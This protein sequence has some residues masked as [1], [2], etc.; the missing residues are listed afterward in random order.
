MVSLMYRDSLDPSFDAKIMTPPIDKLSEAFAKPVCVTDQKGS[1]RETVGDYL[2][3]YGAGSFFQTTTPHAANS[4]PFSQFKLFGG[5]SR[6]TR[7]VDAYCGA[8]PFAIS[9]SAVFE[10][11][12]KIELS[13]TSITS[14]KRN[15]QLNSISSDKISFLPGE[16][17]NIFA[18]VKD[19]PPEQTVVIIDPPR[20]G[21]DDLFLKQLLNFRCCMV[22]SVSCNVHTQARNIELIVRS[23]E[24][25]GEGRRYRMDALRGF[26]LFPQTA[27]VESVALLRLY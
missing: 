10:K 5:G 22:V 3:E 8:G 27:H 15:A 14:A 24:G 6:P 20:K 26:D 13:Q 11:V 9:L 4:D 17:S 19:F 25:D 7:L 1:A 12:A 2:L 23:T 18:T 21:C 16:A